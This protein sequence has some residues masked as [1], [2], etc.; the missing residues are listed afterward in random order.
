[1]VNSATGGYWNPYPVNPAP[2]SSGDSGFRLLADGGHA[3]V[4]DIPR[5]PCKFQGG[6][7]DCDSISE[8]PWPERI[9]PSGR[10]KSATLAIRSQA[11]AAT[12]A[13]GRLLGR[14]SLSTAEKRA[15]RSLERQIEEHRSKLDA[16]RSNPDA[17]DPKG[18]LANAPSQEIRERIIEGRMRHLETE[19][20]AFESQIRRIRKKG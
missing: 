16:Y 2:A 17:F 6:W 3:F 8:D 20:R 7:A 18:M 15:I 13:L 9:L 10:V 12:R 11:K 1:L 4:D 14:S 19:I 5:G